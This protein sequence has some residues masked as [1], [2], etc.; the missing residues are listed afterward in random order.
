MAGDEQAMHMKGRQH[1]QQHIA[2]LEVPVGAQRHGVVREVAVGEHGALGAPGGARGVEDRGEVAGG[3][4]QRRE[5]I[6]LRRGGIDQRAASVVVKFHYVRHAGL[7]RQ[8]VGQRARLRPADE[9]AGFRI[10]EKELQFVALI[11]RVERQ[12]HHAGANRR[13]VEHQR[14][15]GLFHLRRNAVAGLQTQRHDQVGHA[16]RGALDVA[17]GPHPAVGQDH[18]RRGGILRK[19]RGKQRIQVLVHECFI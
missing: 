17:V 7:C 2:R 12:E 9:Q 13:K 16:P 5:G 3:S 14:F 15:R 18:A 10:A 1:V 4:R 11:G 19:V 6:R 8:F